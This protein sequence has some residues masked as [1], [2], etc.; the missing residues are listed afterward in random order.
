MR[1]KKYIYILAALVFSVSVLSQCKNSQGEKKDPRGPAFA[2]AGKC[3]TCHPSVY[4]SFLLSAHYAASAAATPGNIQ[5]SF[6]EGQN[7]FAFEDNSKVKMEQRGSRP[8]QVLY[9]NGEEAGSKPFE[10]SFGIKKA[11]SWLYWTGNNTYQLPVSYY[12][13]VHSWGLS[14]GY[15][16]QFPEFNRLVGRNCFECHSSNINYLHTIA[17]GLPDTGIMSLAGREEMDRLSLVT[18]IDCERCH[19]PAAEHVRFHEQNPAEKK[20][21]FLVAIAGTGRQEQLD[22]C[23]V[24]HSGNDQVKLK[25]RF[26]FRPGDTLSAFFRPPTDT[27][28][29]TEL[30]VH[31]N[32]YGL[33]RQSRCFTQSTTLTCKNCHDPHR[34]ADNSLSYYSAQCM[35]CHKEGSP[36]FC[37]VKPAAGVLLTE[38]CIDCH[39]PNQPSAAISFKLSGSLQRYSYLLRTHRIA[40]YGR[41]GEKLPAGK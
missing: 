27:F 22:A 28:I 39:M 35:N 7:E 5:G 18:G 19:G 4:D 10:I 17:G 15:T 31:G 33:L 38:N 2:G 8:F 36:S 21:R 29:K 34:D 14:P 3:R 24:C 12:T 26:L 1:G 16:S 37:T 25:S 23:A 6:L 41:E 32:Q 20:G 11:Q 40:V 13:S 30:D 9:I